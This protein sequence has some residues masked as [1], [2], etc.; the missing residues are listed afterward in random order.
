MELIIYFQTIRL[1]Y[2]RAVA[3][4]KWGFFFTYTT[5]LFVL[6]TIDM[7][8]N[9]VWAEIMWIDKRDNPGVLGY[10]AESSSVWYQILGS[11]TVV[12]MVLLG[13]AFLVSWRR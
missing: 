8:T 9:A 10:I 5:L 11:T 12:A 6:L 7:S 13:D 3:G 1:L 4:K 2:K